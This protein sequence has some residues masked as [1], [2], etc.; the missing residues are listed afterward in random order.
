MTSPRTA[1]RTRR[2]T[3]TSTV[4]VP[5]KKYDDPESVERALADVGGPDRVTISGSRAHPEHV[6]QNLA[7]IAKK[8]GITPVEAFIRI[9]KDGGA[10][11]I[12][13]SMRAEDVRSSSSSSPG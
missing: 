12:G 13:H 10:D 5:N 11:V 4:L 7:Q 1:T 3:R 8:D 9:V 6:G 2:G